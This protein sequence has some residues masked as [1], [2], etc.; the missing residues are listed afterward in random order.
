MSLREIL[1]PSYGQTTTN[2]VASPTHKRPQ[3]SGGNFARR[4][5]HPIHKRLPLNYINYDGTDIDY[6]DSAPKVKAGSP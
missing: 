2:H 3:S 1:S 4:K 6:G 5:V